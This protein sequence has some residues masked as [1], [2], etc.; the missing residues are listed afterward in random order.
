M[1]PDVNSVNIIT[2][3]IMFWLKTVEIKNVNNE[4]FCDEILY[5]LQQHLG[6]SK[7]YSEYNSDFILIF[8][9]GFKFWI[10]TVEDQNIK[11]INKC[12]MI[13]MT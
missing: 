8:A 4:N 12:D 3:G 2:K 1:T 11:D 7:M 6:S 9:L 10:K 5:Q 13:L